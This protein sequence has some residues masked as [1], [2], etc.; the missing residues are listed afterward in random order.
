MA[1]F[2]RSSFVFDGSH[3]HVTWKCHNDSWLIKRDCFKDLYNELLFKY[4]K[5]YKMTL[6]SKI[7]MDNHIHLSGKCETQELFSNFFK[8]VHS[9]FAKK[10]NHRLGRSGQVIKDRFKSPVIE[11]DADLQS[12]MIYNDLNPSRTKKG[13]H[14]KHYKWS[15]YHHYAYGKK[16][17]LLTEPEW[18]KELGDTPKERQ[19]KYRKLIDEIYKNDDR[20][21]KCPYRGERGYL[22]YVG[23]PSWAAIQY[24]KLLDEY[25]EKRREWQN[26]HYEFLERAM[27]A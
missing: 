1:N 2:A 9:C 25:N 26:R 10:L 23:S 11:S 20:V 14:P 16:D 19:K 12:V 6:I 22:S 4:K 5:Q 24:R 15:S 17:P 18:Y 13:L 3:F 8:T 27:A 21:P 7:Y